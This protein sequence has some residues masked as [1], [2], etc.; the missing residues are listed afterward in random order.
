M[1]L[2]WRGFGK[3]F[4]NQHTGLMEKKPGYT[5]G[6]TFISG[7]TFML[8]GALFLLQLFIP[9][10]VTFLGKRL[11]FPLVTSKEPGSWW[12]EFP[13]LPLQSTVVVCFVMYKKAQPTEQ[14]PAEEVLSVNVHLRR[15]SG[16]PNKPTK[17]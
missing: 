16:V 1:Y 13:S 5:L 8:E 2:Q 11:V 3:H 9:V 15:L 14:T 12:V 17:L 7:E 4:N 6:A 10:N